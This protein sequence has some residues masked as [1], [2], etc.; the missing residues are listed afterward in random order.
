[1]PAAGMEQYSG[2]QL[3]S[4]CQSCQYTTR[5][6]KLPPQT[7]S[8]PP[9]P[10]HVAKLHNTTVMSS[11]LQ[12]LSSVEHRVRC[13]HKIIK[14]KNGKQR[15]SLIIWLIFFLLLQT[16]PSFCRLFAGPS[17]TFLLK[18]WLSEYTRCGVGGWVMMET[19]DTT[20]RRTETS[21]WEIERKQPNFNED[22][23]LPLYLP[24]W[25]SYSYTN[26]YTVQ[27]LLCFINGILSFKVFFSYVGK[28]CCMS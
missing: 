10:A 5:P 27:L 28:K 13:R 11:T 15:Q 7:K 17:W 24:L 4:P 6:L 22:F 3:S 25:M 8:C 14:R 9:P 12:A 26:R 20:S 16:K 23:Y 1:M 2:S 18:Y 21:C 19:S